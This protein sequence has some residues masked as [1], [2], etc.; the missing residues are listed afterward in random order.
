MAAA[1]SDSG[2]QPASTTIKHPSSTP[3]PPPPSMSGDQDPSLTTTRSI[4]SPD[5]AADATPTTPIPTVISSTP[6]TRSGSARIKGKKK[7]DAPSVNSAE[8]SSASASSSTPTRASR[9]ATALQNTVQEQGEQISD[10]LEAIKLL[11]SCMSD[12][13][14]QSSAPS[15]DTDRLHS[16]EVHI[17]DVLAQ[18]SSLR[19]QVDRTS[20]DIRK[21]TDSNN[22]LVDGMDDIRQ[23]QIAYSQVIRDIRQE[24]VEIVH[25]LPVPHSAQPA[26]SSSRK[27][28]RSDSTQGGDIRMPISAPIPAV[29]L[30]TGTPAVS[31][32]NLNPLPAPLPTPAL[33]PTMPSS[34]PAPPAPAPAPT[35]LAHNSQP[36]AYSVM[37]GPIDLSAWR[38]LN[39]AAI[40]IMRLLRN[41]TRLSQQVRGRRGGPSSLVMSWK[42]ETEALAFYHEWH[43]E[44]PKGYESVS[45]LNVNGDLRVKLERPEFKN[46]FDN[47]H[48]VFY[49]ETHLRPDEHECIRIPDG[50]QMFVKSRPGPNDLR[51]PWGGVI[52]FHFVV[53]PH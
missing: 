6:L 49:Q 23:S 32:P 25:R 33:A 7:A 52:A 12:L 34:A 45:M 20:A 37:V 38:N 3:I 21:L 35:G 29:M 10:A 13:A 26:S 2:S 44:P 14:R 27:R 39:E 1:S 41:V 42:S 15:L 40:A 22:A 11:K 30:S 17:E 28:P 19:D 16:L 53:G 43:A 51:R 9:N 31:S 50:F 36:M 47:F 5:A 4:P 46:D 24:I 8:A 48:V 18:Y